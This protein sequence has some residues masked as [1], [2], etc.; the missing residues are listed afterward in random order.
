[1]NLTELSE[2]ASKTPIPPNVFDAVVDKLYNEHEHAVIGSDIK[3]FSIIKKTSSRLH[4]YRLLMLALRLPE[5]DDTNLFLSNYDLKL[6]NK[7][8]EHHIVLDEDV[9]LLVQFIVSRDL[10]GVGVTS[11]NTKLID[12]LQLVNI[13]FTIV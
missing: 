9:E 11:T 13:N 5:S 7:I 10:N 3:T 4:L 8:L 12:L 2:L 1:M 6:V